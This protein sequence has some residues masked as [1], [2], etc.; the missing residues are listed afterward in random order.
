MNETIES[1]LVDGGLV[2]SVM[3]ERTTDGRDER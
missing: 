2:D 1:G 3:L